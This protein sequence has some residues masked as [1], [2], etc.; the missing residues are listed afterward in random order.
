MEI[1]KKV[2][3]LKNN[4]NSP[5]YRPER[6]KEIITLRKL[7]DKPLKVEELRLSH[8]YKER[9]QQQKEEQARIRQQMR[10]EAQLIQKVEKAQKEQEKEKKE[11]EKFVS[12][13]KQPLKTFWVLS[14]L[15][16]S[17]SL[18]FVVK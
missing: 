6:E 9:K 2:G 17:V 18:H 1:V 14:C 13:K 4:T 12:L 16:Y 11:K 5:I 7:R 3:E 15:I 8:E 10:D